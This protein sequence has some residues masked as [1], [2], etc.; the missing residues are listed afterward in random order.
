MLQ[1]SKC[2]KVEKNI[3]GYRNGLQLDTN[4]FLLLSQKGG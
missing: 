4:P 2:Q 1:V 3:F